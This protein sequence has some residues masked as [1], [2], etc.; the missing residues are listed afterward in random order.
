MRGVNLNDMP[1]VQTGAD[2]IAQAL[3]WAAIGT[4]ELS[5]LIKHDEAAL[6]GR[7]TL[8]ARWVA[9]AALAALSEAGPGPVA[10]AMGCGN[11]PLFLLELQ[12][13]RDW[14]NEDLV[15]AVTVSLAADRP[16]AAPAGA[17]RQVTAAVEA[18]L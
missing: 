16:P 10:R 3:V 15:T 6:A 2:R 7:S 1:W 9:F 4:R 11:N 8:R 13:S 14:W 12:R 17:V 18:R 5:M